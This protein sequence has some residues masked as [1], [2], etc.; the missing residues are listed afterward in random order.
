MNPEYAVH[1]DADR[2]FYDAP[3]RVSAS[4][5]SRGALWETAR[6][7]APD[8]WERKRA[9]DWLAYSPLDVRLPAQGWKIHVSAALDNAESV[10]SRVMDHCL[11]RRV[12]FKFVPN[13]Y[14]LHTRN[15]KY[16]DRAASGKFITVY[17]ADDAQ[18]RTLAEELDTLLAGEHGPY[19]LSDL[20]WGDGPVH[21]R[22]G[23]FARRFCRDASGE[24]CPAVE[25]PS[26]ALVPDLRGPVFRTPE[27]VALPDFLAPHLAARSANG[28]A[29]VPYTVE[30]ALHFSNGGG[31]YLGRDNRTGEQVVLKEAR[32]HAGLAADGA[33]AIA[34]LERERAALEQL[35][36]LPCV[37]RVLDTLTLGEHRFLVLEHIAGTTLNTVFARRFP[38]SEADPAPERLA[39]HTAWALRIHDLV[40]R[41]VEA[42]HSR[43]LVISDLH[44]SN[45]I[46]A[47]DE[48]SVVLLDF[49]AASAAAENRRQVV[50]N[51]AFVAPSDRRGTDI[52]TY[53]L[54][55]LR[56]ALFVPLTTLF[57]L[58]R[59]KAAHL[60]DVIARTFP[61]DRALLDDAVAEISR[62]GAAP[63]PVTAAPPSAPAVPPRAAPSGPETWARLRPGDWPHSRDS[64]VRAVLASA[65]FD[66][67]DRC[68]PGD[69][70]QFATPCGG[71]SFGYGAAGVLHALASTGAPPCPD[72][73][74]W[75]LLRSKEPAS[76]SPLGFYDGL[77]GIAWTLDR[78]GHR[79]P[80]LAL[81]HLVTEQPWQGL[82]TDLH[83]GLAGIGLAL[84][85]LAT[86]GAGGAGAAGEDPVLR[87]AADRCVEL[88]ADRLASA[89]AATAAGPGAR[90]GLLHGTTGAALL[91]VRAFERTGDS[92]LLDLAARALRDD[93]SRCVQDDGGALLVR[94][95][96]RTMPYL[97]A[98]SVGIAMVLDDYLAHRDDGELR[99]TREETTR[100]AHS[101]FYIQPGLFRGVA[102]LLLHLARTTGPALPADPRPA[103][104]ADPDG[105]GH[106]AESGRHL[107]RLTELMSWHA[108]PYE[109]EL[110]FPGE[111]LMRLSMDLAT[112]TAGCLL[113]LGSA[114]HDAPVHLPFLPPL[115]RPTSRPHPGV[116][117]K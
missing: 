23:A 13:R 77:A 12:P 82:G 81:A 36:G 106:A 96:R 10:L 39:E 56:L 64:M 15:A 109:G 105:S 11:A 115:R 98:G 101:S 90:T 29:D 111:Q 78:L 9:G 18:C 45:V 60:A 102:G 6:R 76:G 4:R 84:D 66:R 97:G 108:I 14:L 99:R 53:A 73:E 51:P 7:S 85:A 72:A 17:P 100:A 87:Q 61:V 88:V 89:A 55:C 38:L 113:A 20:R 69:I 25:D 50:A 63:V 40:A 52:D 30:R 83:T 47:E 46:V 86:P 28:T 3:H 57:T 31:V 49:E 35:A 8:G 92:A 107:R 74:E 67:E 42:V 117:G 2:H 71:Q 1:C 79:Q 32:P 34:R 54:A 110:A 24:L 41:A 22:Y 65:T 27:W 91:L 75:L 16:A 112:G 70:A 43:G 59:G 21:V 103:H 5:D 62:E 48:S 68:F 26:G 19:V 104:P 116:R 44:M 95:G 37:P 58:D 80:A 93:L 33:D 114:L 94:E